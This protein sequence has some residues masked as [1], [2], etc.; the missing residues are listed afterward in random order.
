MEER[1][2][3]L[4][5]DSLKVTFRQMLN[6]VHPSSFEDCYRQAYTLVQVP[7]GLKG[8]LWGVRDL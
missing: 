7:L 4:M 6:E 2:A 3:T 1:N 8:D 5:L